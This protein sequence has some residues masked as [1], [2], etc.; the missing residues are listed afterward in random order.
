MRQNFQLASF[1]FSP[2]GSGILPV[3][4]HNNNHYPIYTA[5]RNQFYANMTPSARNIGMRARGANREKIIMPTNNGIYRTISPPWHNSSINP[6]TAAADYWCAFAR[7]G[8]VEL[9][10]KRCVDQRHSA[11]RHNCG[12]LSRMQLDFGDHVPFRTQP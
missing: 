5:N 10:A 8:S 12:R 2:M 11:V 9:D 6:N 7:C 4:A 3:A 1:L